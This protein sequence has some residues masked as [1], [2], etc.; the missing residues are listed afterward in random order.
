MDEMFTTATNMAKD[1]GLVK[2]GDLNRVLP[3]ASRR[4]KPELQYAQ[5]REIS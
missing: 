1:C 5:G 2:T 4:D 3:A